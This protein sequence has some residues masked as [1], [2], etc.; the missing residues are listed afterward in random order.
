MAGPGRVNGDFND[1][2]KFLPEAILVIDPQ[3]NILASTYNLNGLFGYAS[4]A[5]LSGMSLFDFVAPIERT[6]VEID[7]NQVIG[8]EDGCDHL[9]LHVRKN[10]TLFSARW[11]VSVCRDETDDPKLLLISIREKSVYASVE[12]NNLI[13]NVIR[14][15]A[16]VIEM[17]DKYTA[18]HQRRVAQLAHQ[19]GRIMALP[20]SEIVL[21]H[22]ESLIHDIGK[23]CVP[24]EYLSKPDRLT[25]AEFGVIRAHPSAG[26]DI[27]ETLDCPASMIAAVFEHHERLD[28]SGYPRGIAGEQICASAK[29]L[30]VCDVVEAISSHRPYRP[31]LGLDRALEEITQGRGVLYESQLVDACVEIFTKNNFKFCQ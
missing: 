24:A 18:R 11:K 19:V 9:Y 17:R 16:Y 15:V 22:M 1:M 21:I 13:E 29:I 25:D 6:Q 12:Q 5:S 27:L 30:A 31:A 23:I 26:R 20:R 8:G 14:A 3:G 28:G 10:Q 2:F 4:T 7:L